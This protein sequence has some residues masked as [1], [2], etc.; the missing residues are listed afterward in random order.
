MEEKAVSALLGISGYKA[1][2]VVSLAVVGIY[3]SKKL[4]DKFCD[5]SVVVNADGKNKTVSK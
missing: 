3:A 1:V 2:A 5:A 4:I